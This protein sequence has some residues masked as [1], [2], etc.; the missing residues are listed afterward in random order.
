MSS[1]QL[2][3]FGA[4]THTEPAGLR[5]ERDFLNHHE[6]AALVAMIMALPLTEMRYKTYMAR[7]RVIS[8]GQQ[9]DFDTHTLHESLKLPSTFQALRERVA[10]WHG[11][12][13]DVFTQVLVAE[14]RPG[15]P[16]GWHRDVPQFEDIVG[17]S[18]AGHA[19]MRFRP[20]PPQNPAKR[21]IVTLDLE[22]RSIY[23]L[24]GSAR[25]QWQHSVAPTA[26]MRYSITFRTRRTE[27]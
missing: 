20:Y 1:D 13:P 7:R 24:S 17:V 10:A 4:P 15:T 27:R 23:L 19:M 18:L 21:S 16:L 2:S 25:W 26:T 5:Y 9:Y 12:A 22:P 11:V 8:Y 3:L 14:Y 6:E